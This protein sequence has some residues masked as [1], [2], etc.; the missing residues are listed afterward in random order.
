MA[1]KAKQT[2]RSIEDLTDEYNRLNERRIQAQTQLDEATKQ[3]ES[4]QEE[5][6]EEFGTSD[7]DELQVKLEQM[8]AENEKR[9]SEYQTLLEG[10]AAD[11]TKVEQDAATNGGDNAME[12][13]NDD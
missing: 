13:S 8:E 1:K 12:E 6:L 9:R 7:V 4:L 2:V 3:L 5:A 10:I 11:L